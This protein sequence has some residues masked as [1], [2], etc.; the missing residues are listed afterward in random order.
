[1][2]QLET[3]VVRIARLLHIEELLDSKPKEVSGGVQQRVS[4]ARAL[5]A[6]AFSF[7]AR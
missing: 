4:L 7:S 3:E 6:K 5:V 2:E 1:M